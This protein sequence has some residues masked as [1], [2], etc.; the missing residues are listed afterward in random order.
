MASGSND[1]PMEHS[2]IVAIPQP[3]T[4]LAGV[5]TEI[6]QLVLQ[7]GGNSN[8][9]V[10][11]QTTLMSMTPNARPTYS[12]PSKAQMET[13]ISYLTHLL[14]ETRSYADSEYVE[15]RIG[16]VKQAEAALAQQRTGFEETAL[17]YER[18]ARAQE[19]E[20]NEKVKQKF[21]AVLR[22]TKNTLEDTQRK[23]AD[24]QNTALQ[25]NGALNT[26]E[27]ILLQQRLELEGARAESQHS[28]EW[29]AAQQADQQR[30]EEHAA[31]LE[32]QL[33]NAVSRC[34]DESVQVVQANLQNRM[35]EESL[36]LSENQ[37]K[38]TY[39]Q[40]IDLTA[41]LHE[42]DEQLASKN[43]EMQELQQRL[44]A[45]SAQAQRD[46]AEQQLE[47]QRLLQKQQE[48]AEEQRMRHN[49]QRLEQQKKLD[50]ATDKLEKLLQNSDRPPCP[51]PLANAGVNLRAN[52]EQRE[53]TLDFVHG[54]NVEA[55]APTLA[56]NV[57]IK[58][59][60]VKMDEILRVLQSQ[61]AT[62]LLYSP[63]KAGGDSCQKS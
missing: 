60:E 3:K 15:Q 5:S 34:S 24:A 44:A 18:R 21:G 35:L 19:H 47:T 17:E 33:R 53:P 1:V 22:G 31:R 8:Q 45:Q 14:G 16:L 32:L 25:Y 56:D 12:S 13:Q 41:R 58:N 36:A 43:N 38:I 48:E 40:N 50:E 11:Q 26:A 23:L 54:L 59:L 30:H 63:G 2:G 55:E 10:Q 9:L 51:S 7:A 28:A 42:F 27:G 37:R 39:Q 6:Q 49:Q 62:T 46:K 57:R 61:R 52:E 29:L 4:P 20:T